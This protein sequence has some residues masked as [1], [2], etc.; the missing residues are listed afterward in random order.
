MEGNCGH[1]KQ[2]ECQYNTLQYYIAL[3][4]FDHDFPIHHAPVLTVRLYP[5]NEYP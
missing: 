5:L 2:V 3:P 4:P 1:K